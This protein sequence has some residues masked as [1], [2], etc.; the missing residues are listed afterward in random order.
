LSR[1]AR[2]GL[3]LVC[4]LAA[5]LL[6]ACGTTNN[7]ADG[8]G[9]G[10]ASS[11]GGGQQRTIGF[12]QVTLQSPFYVALRDAALQE[13]KARGVKLIFLDANGDVSKQN[14]DL[15]DLVTRGV[16]GVLLNPANPEA[17]TPSLEALGAQ[18]IPVVTV[19]RP[20]TS[21][22]KAHV[23]R[24]NVKMGRLVGQEAKRL[25]GAGGGKIIEIQG[26]AG[27]EVMKAR[28]DG[29][30]GVFKGQPNVKI[31]R[32]PYSEYIRANAVSAMQDLL[33]AN[34]DVKLV[35]AHNDDMALGAL[36]VLQQNGLKSVKVTGV[37]GLMEA[38]KAETRGE[39]QATA[40]NDPAYLGKLAVDTMLDVMDGKPVPKF[41]DAGTKL[42]TPA[43]AEQ[44]V[45][46]TLF[47]RY[48]PGG[49]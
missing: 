35:Y 4:L 21:G 3:G 17:V 6:G 38:I 44:F 40:L 13:A 23:G 19:D 31:V 1:F 30:E 42:V 36:Q 14:R 43:N 45:G 33:Q 16:D 27:G 7:P 47:A 15:Q 32:G 2:R 37:D 20:V 34:R 49:E 46:P 41:V 18:K 25:L 26:D 11:G 22:S 9:G 29:F 5:L 24:D 12:S 48:A 8:G 10:Q 39:Y 28:R